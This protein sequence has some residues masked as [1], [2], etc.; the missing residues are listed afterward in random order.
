MWRL[1][2]RSSTIDFIA[3]NND[4]VIAGFIIGIILMII[5]PLPS[6]LLDILLVVNMT[7]GLVIMLIS[8]FTTEPLQFSVFPSLL[9]ITTLFRLAL[10]ISSTR[11]ILATA[12]AGKVIS[13][14]GDFVVQGNYIVGFVV[15]IIIMVVQFVVITNGASRVAEVGARFTL[16]AMPG[17]QMAIDADFNAGIINEEQA[18]DRRAIIQQ[19]ANFFGAMD[20]AT[21]FVKGDA[22]AGI[23]ITIINVIGGLII[24]KLNMG[25]EISEALKTYTLL[26]I[27]DGLVS[28]IPALLIS[29]ATGIVATRS[30]SGSSFGKDVS[31]QMVTF[32]KVIALA[33]AILFI[34]G[35]VP[36]FP[37]LL[38]MTLAVATF[39]LSYALLQEDKK[40]QTQMQEAKAQEAIQEQ[41][42][43]PED[44]LNF[45]K[46]DPLEIEIGY[47]LVSLTD[48]QQGGDLLERL[49]AVRRQCATEMG[50]YVR[51]IRIRDNLQLEPNK[52]I[53][54]IKGIQLAY[55]ELMPNYVMA[56]DP[57]NSGKI[58]DGIPT[59][60]P[61]F[62]LPAVWI[63]NDQKVQAEIKG[64]TIVDATTVMI[65]HLTEFIKKHAHELLGRQEVKEL[66]ELVKENNPA[67]VEDLIPDSLTLGEVQK[68]L[69]N[70]LREHI[71]I[72]DL[73]T[74]LEALSDAARMSKD[75]DYLT[76]Y[77]RLS[78]R[79]TICNLFTDQSDKLYVIT[80]DPKL[81]QILADSIQQIQEGGYTVLEPNIAQIFLER[82]N[83][84]MEKVAYQGILPVLLCSAR[85]R[86]PLRRF[87]ERYIPN[88]PVM[89][90]NEI[91]A[92]IEIESIGMVSV[93]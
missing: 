37:N 10:N 58:L 23:I 75:L 21:K 16:D 27:G 84:I 24:G 73:A 83:N 61:T 13:S 46:V 82:L 9:L 25:M 74:I 88:L 5:I 19:E 3:E 85:I 7:V 4:L 34:L 52:Y 90:M 77:S 54:K 89:S 50:I 60:E 36:A 33:S 20:G 64:F 68:V 65:T 79:R 41:K 2:T 29:T 51:P 66:V 42:Q 56:M 12:N 11:L 49:S 47:D 72:K 81:D 28:Q 71:P 18:K 59:Q 30:A 17:K 91:V 22:I 57:E 31:K 48:E 38:F 1:A 78:L 43:G 26:T 8:L 39:S 76:E 53:F 15:F 67:V 32:P 44:V 62:G 92:E 86:L 55:G 14:F 80:L 45:F 69:Q 87:L 6:I 70:L 35:L 40:N 63:K 93:D